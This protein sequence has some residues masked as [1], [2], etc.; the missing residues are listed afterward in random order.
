M[1]EDE[2]R[3]FAPGGLCMPGGPSTWHVLD[4][5]QRR[6]IA[7]TMDEEQEDEETAV[8]HLRKL[9]GALEPNVHA[10]PLSRDGA[11]ISVSTD[12]RDEVSASVWYPS[13]QE[14]E[15]PDGVETVVWSTLEELER[16]SP[17]VDLVS[18]DPSP[19]G[20]ETI[21]SRKA[22]FKYYFINQFLQRFWHEMNLVIRLP[23]HPNI[24]PFDRLV[25]DDPEG[26]IIGFTTLYMSGGTINKNIS[27]IFKLDWLKQLTRVVD[28]LNLKFGIMH[29]D[30]A[31]R[32]LL[33][34]PKTDAL[35]LFDF[36]YSSRIGHTGH[37][38]E[39]DDVKGVVF[40]IFEM[41]TRDE[42]FRDAAYDQQ[43]PGDVETLDEWVK[44]P[45][46][47]LDHAVS[48]YRAVLNEWA[49]KRRTGNQ[50]AIYTEAPEW[51]D[52]P[53]PNNTPDGITLSWARPAPQSSFDSSDAGT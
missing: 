39:R 25:L 3:Y 8:Q 38:K 48:E 28:D 53:N 35:V 31:S 21:G 12:P 20:T 49:E 23:P 46:V 6:L 16:L 36:N 47:S 13:L 18:Y 29:Q 33:V 26:H 22:V 52:W 24:V 32:N 50:I 5:E 51:I 19:E 10:I 34:N 40:T 41:I 1:I 27:R 42:H 14:V 43:D 7:V 44:H 30:I 9:I 45:E 4:W 17:N 2:R 37:V 15:K 11:L